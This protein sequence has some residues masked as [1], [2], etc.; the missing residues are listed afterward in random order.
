MCLQEKRRQLR[1]KDRLSNGGD[2]TKDA[3]RH[4][5]NPSKSYFT[6][7]YSKFPC[8]TGSTYSMLLSYVLA[9]AFVVI[10][11]FTVKLM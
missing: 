8:V 2:V 4:E 1:A 9:K 10:E 6:L 5:Y 11:K 3:K 7:I